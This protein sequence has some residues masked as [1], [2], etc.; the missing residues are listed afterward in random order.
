MQPTPVIGGVWFLLIGLAG[1]LAGVILLKTG[2]W[3]RR[4]GDAPHCRK[5]DY[6]LTGSV[7]EICP[8]CGTPRTP[9]NIR[10]G[11]RRRD[12]PRIVAGLVCLTIACC[13]FVPATIRTV[14][15]RS[16]VRFYPTSWVIELL[17]SPDWL[18]LRKAWRLTL[19][20]PY[21]IS[22]LE[23]HIGLWNNIIKQR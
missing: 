11:K 22:I 10:Y 19:I 9:R 23:F 20:M 1:V 21:L 18:L 6:N 14:R 13:C 3:P 4:I 17:D 2:I 7:S 8:E 5:C 12:V 16:W 15:Q